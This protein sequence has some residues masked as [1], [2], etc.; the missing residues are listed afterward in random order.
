MLDHEELVLRA[1]AQYDI[2]NEN[3]CIFFQKPSIVLPAAAKTEIQDDVIQTLRTTGHKIDYQYQSSG[4]Q[5][6]VTWMAIARVDGQECGR[7]V[8][9]NKRGAQKMAAEEALK[10]VRQQL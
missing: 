8:A 7:G 2:V 9:N 6:D 1:K 4:P 5:H 3:G 10:V